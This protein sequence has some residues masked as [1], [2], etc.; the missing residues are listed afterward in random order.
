MTESE[1][2]THWA[3]ARW[4]III[5]QIAPT[6]L[7]TATVGMLAAGL[8][9]SDLPVR[10]AAAGIL[11]AS[12]LLGAAAQIAAA[13]E[14]RAIVAELR[15]LEARSAIAERIIATARGIEIVRIVGPAVF[16]LVFVAL[17][18]ALFW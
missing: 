17:L 9:D 3:S 7:L 5:S 6:L 16:V 4:H 1:L 8:A 13:N 12:G 2:L 11:L 18:W 14:G 15:A 10:L